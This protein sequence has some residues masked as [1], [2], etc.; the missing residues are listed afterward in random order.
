MT[1]Y[2]LVQ[3]WLDDRFMICED[4]AL[5]YTNLR[6]GN[7]IG[8]NASNPFRYVTTSS[9]NPSPSAD[10][11]PPH[12][13]DGAK[14]AMSHLLL[15]VLID[16]GVDNLQ[17]WPA[18]VTNPVSGQTWDDYVVFNVIGSADCVDLGA[19]E[20]TVLME[21]ASYGGGP[22]PLV[23]LTKIMLKRGFTTNVKMFREMLKG[24]LIVND[25]VVAALK[26][27]TPP[28][29]WGVRVIALEHADG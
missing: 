21:G 6:S 17:T 16:A 25:E 27:T 8:L 28:D 10:T 12:F 14:P 11:E 29:K 9:S 24:S 5:R 23:D 15:Q 1:L 3:D 26:R 13:E 19:S 4:N 2:H 7:V 18:I 20:G 22:P